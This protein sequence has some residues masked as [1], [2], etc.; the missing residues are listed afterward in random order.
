MTELDFCYRAIEGYACVDCQA[1]AEVFCD[2]A[3]E[4]LCDSCHATHH[5]AELDE[6]VSDA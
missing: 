2:R 6:A 4:W 5:R 3:D 1:D